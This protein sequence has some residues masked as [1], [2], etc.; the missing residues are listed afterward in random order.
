[1]KHL[2]LTL[3]ALLS[4]HAFAGGGTDV[5]GGGESVVVEGETTL[6]DLLDETVCE[7]EEG[8]KFIKRI[9]LFPKVVESIED[10][11][12][13]LAYQ[14]RKEVPKLKIC[15]TNGYLKKLS[16]KEQDEVTLY[17]EKSDQVAVRIEDRIYLSMPIYNRMSSLAR[18]Y[19]MLHEIFHSF[20]PIEEDE[21]RWTAQGR[22]EN[23]GWVEDVTRVKDQ[24]ASR[25]VAPRERHQRIRSMVAMVQRNYRQPMSRDDFA[26]QLVTNFPGFGAPAF[27]GAE[28]TACVP[29]YKKLR[30]AAKDTGTAPTLEV[31]LASYTILDD[32]CARFFSSL[33]NHGEQDEVV[34][35]GVEFSVELYEA[36]KAGDLD[37]AR[38][39][40]GMG[41]RAYHP[42]HYGYSI[43]SNL[44]KKWRTLIG[45]VIEG[46]DIPRA[47]AIVELTTKF[48]DKAIYQILSQPTGQFDVY[49]FL[50]SRKLDSIRA[51]SILASATPAEEARWW[52]FY[53][54]SYGYSSPSER[55]VPDTKTRDSIFE[56]CGR[57]KPYLA[58]DPISPH[59]YLEEVHVRPLGSVLL[60]KDWDGARAMLFGTANAPTDAIDAKSSVIF[61]YKYEYS[62]GYRNSYGSVLRE[63]MRRHYNCPDGLPL[64][65]A[66][67]VGAPADIVGEL[68]RR[69]SER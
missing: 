45:E 50:K 10:T 52:H 49:A 65:V 51:W 58:S 55:L 46:G 15:K 23:G 4:L 61:D 8:A 27:D 53:P 30:K 6:R 69:S 24:G 11:Y 22:F 62:Y 38:A 67:T 3:A 5:G 12:W 35:F 31:K 29:L 14:V 68:V 32:G 1:M 9:E 44:G 54:R 41:A 21:Y 60:K 19:L 47:E 39:L 7:W 66:K 63:S 48:G 64:T 57:Y 28:E 40:V 43:G 36:F 34:R 37:K 17:R 26:Y 25:R 59:L 16:V 18:A 2:I 20:L 33:E 42:R 13:D 56:I